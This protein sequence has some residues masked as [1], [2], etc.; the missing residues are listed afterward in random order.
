M[1]EVKS[2]EGEK[3]NFNVS[4]EKVPRF[5]NTDKCTGCGQCEE[6]CPV[7]IKSEYNMGLSTKK[8]AY[9]NYAQAVPGAFVISKLD[10]AP[11]RKACP[12]GL[13]V[14]GYV[15]MVKQGKYEQALNIIM[16]E[17]PLPGI[18]GR[19][20][21]RFCEDACRRCE[22][23]EPVAIR[24]LKRLAADQFDPR[25]VHINCAP[26]RDEN[27]A[28]IG[29]GPAGLSAAYHLAR[30]GI[31]ATIHEAGS[32]AGG[33]LRMGIP[34]HRL[35]REILDQEI[36]V[37]TNL[38]VEIKLNSSL[39]KD[40][41]L[42]D[43]FDQG[44]KAVFLA[45]GAHVAM[46]LGIP[47]EKTAGVRQGVDF[48]REVNSTG[49]AQIGNKVAIVGGGNVAVDVARV[50]CRLGAKE[51]N[52]VYR[53]TKAEM[54]ALP[55]EIEAA[56]EEGI[57]IY[58]LAAPQE[59]QTRDGEITG[60]RCIQMELGEPDSS[61]RRRPVPVPGSEYDLE[62]DQVIPAIGQK[63]DISML[64]DLEDL[65]FTRWGTIDVDP[66]T[67]S[68]NMQGVFAG[69]DA[70]TGPWIVIGAVAAGR[71]A[72]ESIYRYIDGKDM[73]AGREPVDEIAEPNYRPIPND[74]CEVSRCKMP[75]LEPEER[76]CSFKE[77]EL[78]FDPESGSREAD[79]CLNCGNCSECMQCVE[80]CQ[81]DAIE[82]DQIATQKDLNVGSI[83][84]SAG[85]Q[86]FDP[87]NL[88]LY[89][90]KNFAN[91]ITSMEFER[92]LSATG[93]FQGDLIRPSD[94]SHPKKIAWLQCVG[95]RDINRC[96]NAYCSSVCCMYAIKQSVIAKEHTDEPLDTAIFYMDIRAFGKDFEKY[97]QSAKQEQGVR[98][99]P[100]RIH[101]LEED[102]KTGDLILEYLDEN[103]E[104]QKET[105]DLVILSTGMETSPQFRELS[106]RL[107][108]ELDKDNLVESSTF[109]PVGTS[110]DGIYACG[111]I[112]EPKDIPGSV[113][114]ASA[115]ACEAEKALWEVRGSETQS[116]TY[117]EERPV[118]EQE[119]KI[120]VFVCNCGSNIGGIVEV[121]QVV[122]YAQGL[123][124]VEYVEDNLFTCS[125]DT[126]DKMKE[127]ILEKGLNRIVVAACTPKTHEPL[128]Q[129][130][131]QEVGLNKYLFEMANIRNQCSWVHKNNPELATQKAKDLVSMA[132]SKCRRIQPLEQPTIG[133]NNNA[134]V[135]GG[136]VAGMSAALG[137]TEQGFHTYLVER[138]AELGGNALYLSSTWKGEDVQSGLQDMIKRVENNKLI[139][140]YT[141]AELK[142]ATGFVGNFKTTITADSV[143][144]TLEHGV[145]IIATGGKEY[146]PTEY[147][148]GQDERIL[149][150]LELD[151]AM[152][153]REQRVE[154][155]NTAVFIQC[156]GSREPER[157]YCSKV[158]CTHSIK[159]A[160]S[161][162]KNN[163][164][165]Q[166]YILY[167]DIRTY[168]Q[169]E[170]LYQEARNLGI[171]FIRYNV[172]EKPKVT[173]DGSELN[174]RVKDH[175]LQQELEIGT[176]LIVLASAIIPRDND[177][178]SS[179]FKLPLTEDNFFM[180]AHAKLR[181][182]E[183]TND[184]LFVTGMA[185]YP[186][187]LEESI[188][189][190]KAAASRA[191]EI[192]SKDQI[193]LEGEVSQVDEERCSGC[194]ECVEACPYNAIGLEVLDSGRT[195]ARVQAALCKGCGICAATCPSHS[196]KLK[197]YK[198]DQLFAQIRAAI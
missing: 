145:V 111:A 103:G 41:Q 152:A 101:S 136:G 79:R 26:N 189:Q 102:R 35:P 148:Y 188:S 139:D 56:L 30:K 34:E 198:P 7:E 109:N 165:M 149:T 196:I 70:Q 47:G 39:G 58:F 86:S 12:A 112:Q 82:H 174:V 184:G 57:N 55:E 63:P 104:R 175:I 66:V 15:Q 155:A 42:K 73:R 23:D 90:Y 129:E 164:E 98:F 68:T 122:E 167:R 135:V 1:S 72:A 10:K 77:V 194:G 2:V 6:V 97:Y 166:I 43:L 146:K 78:G 61:G 153:N 115:A 49:T 48:L 160:I 99:V 193:T 133:V 114:E 93:P 140:V 52:I 150:H 24:A 142:E 69:G 141:N 67:Y 168:G 116:K 171:V 65:E 76:K 25:E 110:R 31:Q 64:E 37:I 154:K 137:L 158:C 19:V 195:V 14:Q 106:Q 161:M 134:M 71:E 9:R 88:D 177:T 190:A 183:F 197:G 84:V 46:P 45:I 4:L 108:I 124:K 120:G 162:K 169:R 157:P 121:P 131:L 126:Q 44:N 96:N 33:M 179:M 92:I 113:V 181:P 13:N 191:T 172:D 8:A 132:V 81:T 18:L 170:E 87:T 130:T 180:E 95:S 185:H 119:P 107:D 50:A 75:E 159:S 83:I 173:K 143:D 118:A 74:I 105:F 3:G 176:D 20:C 40:F 51:V 127:I 53:R 100:S 32:Q 117:P 156:V 138:S 27:V 123:S 187:P 16:Q 62:V 89:Q 22:V 60:L 147:L 144:I 163:P 192:L 125:Q 54:P 80:V 28:I 128:F 91:V 178:I 29:S 186:K 59:I 182:V 94:H 21:P 36:E 151:S 5:I 85:F 38:G 17:L 11:C